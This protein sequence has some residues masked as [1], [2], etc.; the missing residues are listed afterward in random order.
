[1]ASKKQTLP[2]MN[3]GRIP[4]TTARKTTSTAMPTAARMKAGKGISNGVK[5]GKPVGC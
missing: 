5:P 1:M 2:A 4:A 3:P